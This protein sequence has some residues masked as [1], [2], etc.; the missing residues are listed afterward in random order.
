MKPAKITEDELQKI[1]YEY[2]GEMCCETKLH[3]PNQLWRWRDELIIY[4]PET[5]TVVWRWYN[6]PHYQCDYFGQ[7]TGTFA[8][9]EGRRHEEK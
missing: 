9:G 1:G 2:L 6:E 4:D 7:G 3:T 8:V 5:Q